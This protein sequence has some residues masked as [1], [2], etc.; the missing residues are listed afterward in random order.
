MM[1]W[2]AEAAEGAVYVGKP[3]PARDTESLVSLAQYIVRGA[4][5]EERLPVS[6]GLDGTS[7]VMFLGSGRNPTF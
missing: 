7:R 6:E 3:V 2:K 1:S 4:V 5:A